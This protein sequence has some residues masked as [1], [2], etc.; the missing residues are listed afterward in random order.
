MKLIEENKTKVNTQINKQIKLMEVHMSRNLGY[1]AIVALVAILCS[2]QVLAQSGLGAAQNITTNAVVYKSLKITD[3]V[4]FTFGHVMVGVNPTVP[5]DG[6]G[7]TGII[8]GSS[9]G[10]LTVAGSSGSQVLFTWDSQ[11]D[12]NSGGNK[13]KYTADIYDNTNAKKVTTS[14]V[15][16]TGGTIQLSVG[17]ELFDGTYGNTIVPTDQ[18]SGTYSADLNIKVDYYQ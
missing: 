9:L 7:V 4:N 17:G 5:A 18:A 14:A 1:I 2:Q 12:L 15:T 13:M 3:P 10:G 8:S 11:I 16:L 6:S